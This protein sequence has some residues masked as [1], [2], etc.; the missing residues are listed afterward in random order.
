MDLVD[1]MEWL[2]A[3]VEDPKPLLEAEHI[4][5][6]FPKGQVTYKQM[7]DGAHCI[8]PCGRLA[9]FVHARAI[10]DRIEEAI[11]RVRSFTATD[12]TLTQKELELAQSSE[13]RIY[14]VCSLAGGTGSG[15]FLDV[16]Y[17]CRSVMDRVN[18]RLAGIFLLPKIFR[19]ETDKAPRNL[20]GNTYAAIK[21]LDFLMTRG[22][23]GDA[24]EDVVQYGPGPF[25]VDW[26]ESAPLDQIF[27]VDYQNEQLQAVDNL[28]DLQEFIG[29]TL[30]INTGIAVGT[31]ASIWNNELDGRGAGEESDSS[32]AARYAGIGCSAVEL[33]IED[34]FEHAVLSKLTSVIQ[35]GF[36][37][38]S[39]EGSLRKA[40]R[41][42]LREAQLDEEGG[43]PI[44]D[45]FIGKN[46]YETPAEAKEPW[47]DRNPDKEISRWL[48]SEEARI[49]KAYEGMIDTPVEAEDGSPITKLEA[50]KSSAKAR[51]DKKLEDI[52]KSDQGSVAYAIEFL[53]ELMG[54]LVAD[55]KVLA[56]EIATESSQKLEA[57]RRSKLLDEKELKKQ[58]HRMFARGRIEGIAQDYFE[59]LNVFSQA[60]KDRLKREQ[61]I[62]VLDELAAYCESKISPLEQIEQKLRG[63]L[64]LV[65]E[66]K[67]KCELSK[68]SNSFTYRLPVDSLSSEVQGLDEDNPDSAIVRK[69]ADEMQDSLLSWAEDEITARAIVATLRRSVEDSYTKLKDYDIEHVVRKTATSDEASL[70]M[71]LNQRLVERAT[72]MWRVLDAKHLRDITDIFLIGV[73]DADDTALEKGR[74]AELGRFVSQRSFMFAKTNSPLEISAFRF[75]CYAKANEVLAFERYRDLYLAGESE[76]KHT[77]HIRRAWA[78]SPELIGD[79]QEVERITGTQEQLLWWV[80][81]KADVFDRIVRHGNFWHVRNDVTG[82][83]DKLGQ[84]RIQAYEE[85][86]RRAQSTSLLEAIEKEV[87]R[88]Y[89]QLEEAHVVGKLK[90]Y[91]HALVDEERAAS[92]AELREQIENE[93]KALRDYLKEAHRELVSPPQEGHGP[94]QAPGSGPTDPEEDSNAAGPAQSDESGVPET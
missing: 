27:L 37:T 25:A 19:I 52:I 36:L 75:K 44:I 26:A 61:G 59:Y 5:A 24:Q 58:C 11:T 69:A 64:N 29:K 50:M 32:K 86:I 79:I 4:A 55:R 67:R 45:Y 15:I 42:F 88:K 56:S 1:G 40:V 82:K 30:F 49:L 20:E 91:F 90:E 92:T 16:A 46:T 43:D 80:L 38:G 51:V 23:R 18:D 9:A 57:A 94:I 14:L 65:S 28:R 17:L 35:N 77:H 34:I 53:Q 76:S 78:H 87:E 47:T 3:K 6:E 81:G 54:M 72:P 84:G 70:K 83:L 73:K 93:W 10:R 21:E 22:Q 13:V 74:A 66:E 33:P 60:T 8:R 62:Q 63:A 12:S 71:L 31:A 2:Y 89:L 39:P 68:P 41:D 85:F 7:I 48:S